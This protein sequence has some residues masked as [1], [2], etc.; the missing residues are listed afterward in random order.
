MFEVPARDW[1][2]PCRA[3]RARLAVKT[4]GLVGASTLAICSPLMAAPAQASPMARVLVAKA[5]LQGSNGTTADEFGYVTAISGSFLAIGAPFHPGG[6]CVYV[7][8]RTGARWRQVAIL[9]GVHQQATDQFGN[10]LK[11]VGSELIV[12]ADRAHNGVG[13]AYVFEYG[14]EGWALQAELAPSTP[15]AGGT[16]GISVAIYRDEAIVGTEYAGQAYAYQ[17]TASGWHQ[18]AIL[19]SATSPAASEYGFWVGVYGPTAVVGADT[20]GAG[21]VY[22]YR[23][24]G[25]GWAQAAEVADPSQ[26]G[27]FH[28][29]QNLAI[30]GNTIVVN[31]PYTNSSEGSVYVISKTAA[32]AWKITSTLMPAGIGAGDWYGWY[33]A[34]NANRIVAGASKFQGARGSAY[35]FTNLRGRWVETAEVLAG[36]RMPNDQFGAAVGISGT[37]VA[38]G[39]FLHS[40][41]RAYVVTA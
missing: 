40:G 11:I 16:Y 4:L 15:V 32:G 36:D 27:A 35:V 18:T 1:R 6:G 34:I 26:A 20:Q 31:A 7:F 8:R 17:H 30:Y 21:A 41:G 29:G 19:T 23:R 12:G 22:I 24:S 33:V 13:R 38:V 14:P 37:T 9:K 2:S 10:D 28:F 5:E 3:R 39:A 25:A